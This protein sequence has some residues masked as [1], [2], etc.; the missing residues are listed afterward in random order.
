MCSTRCATGDIPKD[1]VNDLGIIYSVWL[2][3]SV[4]EVD[5]VAEHCTVRMDEL[6][7]PRQKLRTTLLP[8]PF[9]V[10][11]SHY[12]YRW[13]PLRLARPG[14]ET[15]L[16][17]VSSLPVGRQ[18]SGGWA[19]MDCGTVSQMRTVESPDAE[20]SRVPSGLKATAWT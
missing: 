8:T 2:D 9:H 10:S 7:V 14:A 15:W 1:K 16:V 20:A 18:S 4:T 17:R 5:D 12:L 3:P 19:R 11:L 13:T 6:G